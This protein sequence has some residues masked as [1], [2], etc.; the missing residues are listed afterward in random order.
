MS[1]IRGSRLRSVSWMIALAVVVLFAAQALQAKTYKDKDLKGTYQFIVSEV[2]IQGA[3]LEYCSQYGSADFDGHGAA[4]ILTVMRRCTLYPDGAI[5]VDMDELDAF[6]YEVYPN[7]E[8]LLIELDDMG[9]E[10]D[11]VTH[12]RILQ[13]GKLLLFDGTASFPHHPD[14]LLTTA[15]AAKE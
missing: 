7:G 5:D 11:Y 15:V 13:K 2:R 3:D 4:E 14:F 9:A 12:G 8:L 6:H 1:G 10:T